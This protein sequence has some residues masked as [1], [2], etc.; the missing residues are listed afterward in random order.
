[1]LCL[2]EGLIP[3]EILDEDEETEFD[4]EIEKI[5]AMP[6]T[7]EH[8]HRLYVFA[9]IWG[10]GALLEK[11]DRLKYDE[12][13]RS[14]FESLDLPLSEV[15]PKATVFNFFVNETGEWDSWSSILTNYVYPDSST[16]DFNSILVPITDNVRIQYLIDL[17][18][19]Q[20]R[21][22]LLIGEQGSAK[23]VMMKA[24][25]R[26]ANPET[27]LNRSFNFSSATSPFQFQKTIESYVE[28]RM[29]STFGPPGG[30]KMIIFVD[31]IN[32]PEIN[33]WG[34]QITNE[35]VRQAMDMKGFYSLEKPG[36]FTTVTDVNFMAAMG[37][38]G[39]GR[40]DIPSRLKRQ[41][42]IFNCT[43]PDNASI[44][45]IFSV[46]GEGYYNIKRGFSAEI[47]DL[48]KKLV[49]I[50]RILWQNTRLKLL[51]TPAKFHYVFNLRDLSR[52][53]Q[54]MLGTLSTVIDKEEILML[55]WKHEYKRVFS[56]RLIYLADKEWF[57][58]ELVSVI[59]DSLGQ[60]YV[61]MI[62]QSPSFVDF[63]R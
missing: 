3:P 25:M 26:Q 58:N 39:G 24:Y 29:G 37:Q 15:D 16:P 9:L 59:K 63:M 52:I 62:Q 49:E 5:K 47:R 19:K 31:D 1:M 18:G 17:I 57:N 33:E 50:T 7:A 28:K 42:C 11:D 45:R 38:P 6:I 53:W 41:F 14:N 35:I 55:L 20:D 60:S 61:N 54:G 23:T 2:L 21:P 43:I 36:D 44:D 48:V 8:L 4:N 13:L 34:D 27:T 10:I 32:L 46:L 30:K 40:N 51:P 56:D 22:V 12:Y